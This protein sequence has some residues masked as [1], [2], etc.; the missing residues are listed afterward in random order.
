MRK[1]TEAQRVTLNFMDGKMFVHAQSVGR[2][3]YESEVA[4]GSNLSAIGGAVLGGLRKREW[5][6]FL[7]DEGLWRTPAGRRALEQS[8]GK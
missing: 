5:S 2:A 3:V 7:R 4:A 8:E 1:M 6:A